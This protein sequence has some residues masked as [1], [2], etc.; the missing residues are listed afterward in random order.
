[1]MGTHPT[2][3]RLFYRYMIRDV[4]TRVFDT[5]VAVILAADW[6]V[7]AGVAAGDPDDADRGALEANQ[8]AEVCDNAEEAEKA[9]SALSLK[10]C[11]MMNY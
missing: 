7:V 1:M 8:V 2:E 6:L 9:C 4:G 11:R 5:H 10:R 3:T